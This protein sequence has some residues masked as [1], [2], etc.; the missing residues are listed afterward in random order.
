[1]KSLKDMI[2]ELVLELAGEETV[3]LVDSLWEKENVSEF[4]LSDDL[5]LHINYVRSL[6][7]R[8]STHNL[9]RSIRKKDRQKGWYIYYWTL[10]VRHAQYLVLNKKNHRLNELKD[11]LSHNKSIETYICPNECVVYNL[12]EAMEHEFK[13]P[14][15]ESIL[16]AHSKTHKA[17]EVEAEIKSLEEE[18]TELNKPIVMPK[19][20][21]ERKKVIKKKPVK[22]VSK[23][24]V[25]KA[26]KIVKKKVKA[27]KKKKQVK[28]IKK[29]IMKKKVVKKRQIKKARKNLR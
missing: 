6:L 28:K 22:K 3:P 11:I 18:I 13:C 16:K 4:K 17:E 25:K 19:R 24:K 15:C 23:K 7:Y 12:E 8:L 10:N 29:K 9:L 20:R 21:E 27:I 5:K 1:M 26:K 14:E 2:K